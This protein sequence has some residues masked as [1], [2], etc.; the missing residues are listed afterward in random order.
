MQ[1]RWRRVFF[2]QLHWYC[3]DSQKSFLFNDG[4]GQTHQLNQ[5]AVDTLQLLDE[6]EL[7][8]EKICARLA[9]LYQDLDLN[10]ETY[11]YIRAM[12]ANLDELGLIEPY[13]A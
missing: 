9:E 12:L 11:D 7:D 6:E 13:T 4:S 1:I 5:L 3:W 10:A 8:A 2:P